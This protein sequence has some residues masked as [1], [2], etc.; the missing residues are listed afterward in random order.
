[1]VASMCFGDLDSGSL[2]GRERELASHARRLCSDRKHMLSD[3][4]EYTVSCGG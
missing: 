1:M 2:V 4:L 3:Y